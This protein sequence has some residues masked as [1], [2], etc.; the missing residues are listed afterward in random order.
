MWAGR[1]EITGKAQAKSRNRSR[2]KHTWAG[3][4]K[5][6]E[7]AHERSKKEKPEEAYVGL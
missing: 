7:K 2:R 3:E 4:G 5:I 6:L 1:E